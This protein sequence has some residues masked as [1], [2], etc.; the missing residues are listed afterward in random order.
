M[1][2][3]LGG[4][5]VTGRSYEV[6]GNHVLDGSAAIPGSAGITASGGQAL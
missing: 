4:H 3:S 2:W 5:T 6:D 1:T